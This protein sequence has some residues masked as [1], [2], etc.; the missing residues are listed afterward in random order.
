MPSPNANESAIAE[1][2]VRLLSHFATA[3]EPLVVRREIAA[4]W[5]EDF[6][7][8]TPDQVQWAAREW[9]RTQTLRPA[10]AELRMLA[11]RAQHND[12]KARALPGLAPSDDLWENPA[13][14]HRA[15]K[16]EEER[17]RRA[18]AYRQGRL[19]EYDATHHPERLANRRSEREALQLQAKARSQTQHASEA[20]SKALDDLGISS[21]E[22]AE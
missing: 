22:A 7:E 1:I 14:R 4:D 11:T 9:R 2:I 19:D 16:A 3:D 15:L 6:S 12:L 17:Y 21:T 18:E 13:Q 10:I 8:F 20:V 5:L